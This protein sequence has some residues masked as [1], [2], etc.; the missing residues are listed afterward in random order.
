MEQD[1]ETQMLQAIFSS[2]NSHPPIVV[3]PDEQKRFIIKHASGLT[4]EGK[5]DI[6]N[7]L[8]SCGMKSYLHSCAEG[9]AVNLDAL[10][11]TAVE[12]I[13]ILIHHKIKK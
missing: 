5:K 1:I 13:Y 10:P 8:I 11:T 4:P 2:Q 3:T 7:V 9:T 12:Q 6:G